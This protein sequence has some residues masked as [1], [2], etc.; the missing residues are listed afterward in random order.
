MGYAAI[1][2]AVVTGVMAYSSQKQQSAQ[3]KYQS[4]VASN[5]Q[6][7][8]EIKAADAINRGELEERKHR[9]QLAQLIGEQRAGAA[10]SGVLV[11][12]GSALDVVL[13]TASIGEL[14]ALTIRSNAEREALGFRQQANQFG[15]DAAFLG[16]S[17]K[18]LS[19]NALFAGGATAL[20]SAINVNA[21]WAD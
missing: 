21:K 19:S 15:G 7:I 4:Q 14:E 6:K 16:S 12:E 8:A 1:A 10:A 20:T 13:D 9:I 17:A 18:S 5:N 2:Y 11:D 3:L